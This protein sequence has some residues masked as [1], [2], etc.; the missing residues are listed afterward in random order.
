MLEKKT[1]I[2]RIEVLPESGHIQIR[3]RIS[4][5]EDGNELSYTFHRYVLEKGADLSSQPDKLKAVARA[6]WGINEI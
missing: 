1:T 5:M 3:Q 2:D 4:I 6:A